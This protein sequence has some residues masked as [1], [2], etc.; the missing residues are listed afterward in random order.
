MR[1]RD[2]IFCF[3]IIGICL[4]WK[5]K[6]GLRRFQLKN[7]VMTNNK[8]RKP[9][10][11]IVSRLMWF[12]APSMTAKII[13][14]AFFSSRNMR[15]DDSHQTLLAKAERFEVMALG[16]TIQC[17]KWGS[18]PS[19]LLVHGW[20][21]RGI[22]LAPLI[23]PL[24][25]SGYS[26][27]A[28]DSLAHGES[29]G[30]TTNFFELVESVSAVFDHIGE[31]DF[32]IAHSMGAAAAV[33][34]R[35]KNGKKMKFVLIAPIYDLHRVIYAFGEAS[36]LHMPVYENIIHDVENNFGKT[37]NDVSPMT[38]AGDIKAPVL[39]FHD[40]DDM[41]VPVKHGEALA[42][43]LEDA[44]LVKTSGLGHNRILKSKELVER[45]IEF[46]DE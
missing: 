9:V 27:I 5:E 39:I 36:G 26:V 43:K 11:S 44:R 22:K 31:A 24:V 21:M 41:T 45:V 23:N 14:K 19:V 34:L 42:E 8:I 40:E 35:S 33:N 46:L 37:L 4:Y 29:E 15:V 2:L 18:G 12:V 13:K 10:I 1:K 6:A 32:V 20:G 3:H 30:D 38:I 16:K 25:E 28:Y 17:W 7:N